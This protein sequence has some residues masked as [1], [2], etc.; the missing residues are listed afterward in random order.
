VSEPS[1][2]ARA[3]EA[4]EIEDVFLIASECRVARELNPQAPILEFGYGFNGGI[5]PEVLVQQRG[6][7]DGANPVFILRYYVNA[8]V[9]ILKP[10]VRAEKQED[11]TEENTLAYIRLEVATDYRGLEEL[12]RNPEVVGSFSRNA[13]YHAWPYLR[14][15]VHAMCSRLR[16]PR[17]TLPMMKPNQ[18]G[19]PRM[20]TVQDAKKGD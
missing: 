19:I 18:L 4:F 13:Y 12:V 5:G 2:G 8:E 7:A 20:L 16:V 14:E 9:R 11:F 10:E 17:I 1:P 6:D 15:E 3:V